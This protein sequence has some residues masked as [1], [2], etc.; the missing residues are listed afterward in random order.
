[1]RH[2]PDE[3]IDVCSEPPFGVVGTQIVEY[4]EHAPEGVVDV[5]SRKCRTEGCGEILLFR[6]AS[7]KT[8]E[9]SAQHTQGGIVGVNNRECRTVNCDMKS[10]FGVARTITME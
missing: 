2:A 1:M 8:A 6:V 9:Y 4:C 3:M 5:C 7:T 10:S